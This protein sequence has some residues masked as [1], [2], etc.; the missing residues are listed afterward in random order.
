MQKNFCSILYDVVV[1]IH[2]EIA[3]VLK[4]KSKYQIQSSP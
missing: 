4:S 1:I 2:Q 3:R